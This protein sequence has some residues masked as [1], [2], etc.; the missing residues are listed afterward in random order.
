[1]TNNC[2]ER[3]Y[4]RRRFGMRPGLETLQALLARLGNPEAGLAVVH[5]AGIQSQKRRGFAGSGWVLRPGRSSWVPE[6]RRGQMNSLMPLTR[7]GPRS[8]AHRLPTSPAPRCRRRLSVGIPARHPVALMRSGQAGRAR[9][10][11]KRWCQHEAGPEKRKPG[12]DRA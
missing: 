5:V 6:C 3:L 11:R 10:C 12:G 8:Q 7:S 2:L 9:F 1:M 4:A